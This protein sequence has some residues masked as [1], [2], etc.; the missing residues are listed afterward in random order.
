MTEMNTKIEIPMNDGDRLVAEINPNV[1][2]REIFVG[3]VNK[4]GV[5]VQDLACIGQ[6]YEIEDDLSVKNVDNFY[7]VRCWTD[8]DSEDMTHSFLIPRTSGE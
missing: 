2:F 7:R 5:W 4:E 8:A 6:D 3:I 1:P